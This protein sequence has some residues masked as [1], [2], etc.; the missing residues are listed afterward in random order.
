MQQT[1]FKELCAQ[2]RRTWTKKS[3]AVALLK[4]KHV[5]QRSYRLCAGVTDNTG[6]MAEYCVLWDCESGDMLYSGK[7]DHIGLRKVF[8]QLGVCSAAV[9]TVK[10][11]QSATRRDYLCLGS[12]DGCKVSACFMS[13]AYAGRRTRCLTNSCTKH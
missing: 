12:P 2:V 13:P 1:K 9:T 10:R 11:L 4:T 8:T 7:L 3:G 5:K 6:L